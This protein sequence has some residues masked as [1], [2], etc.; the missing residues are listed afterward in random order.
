MRVPDEVPAAGVLSSYATDARYP[1]LSE[2]VDADE[3]ERAM[4]MAAAV[5]AFAE[6]AIA[7]GS[8]GDDDGPQ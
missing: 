4:R 7:S 8:R 1:G 5:V 3:Y 2:P 6:K